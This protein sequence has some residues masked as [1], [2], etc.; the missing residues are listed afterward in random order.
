AK[1]QKRKGEAICLALASAVPIPREII[2]IIE[3]NQ[4]F[5]LNV[6]KLKVKETTEQIKPTMPV[7]K[8]VILILFTP[9]AI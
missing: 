3:K 2:V 7:I 8:A 5:L 9:F 1:R 4:C 6:I